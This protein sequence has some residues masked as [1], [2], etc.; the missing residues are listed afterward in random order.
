M[1]L[2]L[3]LEI[4]LTFAKESIVELEAIVQVVTVLVKHP[5]SMSKIFAKTYVKGL[6]VDRVGPV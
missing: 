3:S 2:L 6:S 4:T 5:L 1:L